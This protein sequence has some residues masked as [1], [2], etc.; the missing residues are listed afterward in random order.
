[1]FKIIHFRF[2]FESL[3]CGQIRRTKSPGDSTKSQLF[4]YPELFIHT[5][6]LSYFRK[7]QQWRLSCDIIRSIFLRAIAISALPS[8]RIE[9]DF[10]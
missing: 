5:E 10:N 4:Y 7:Q 1:M 8:V 6:R 9:N 3:T 2:K